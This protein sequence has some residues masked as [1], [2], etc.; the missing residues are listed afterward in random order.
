MD[1]DQRRAA[2]WARIAAIRDELDELL[3]EL[4]AEPQRRRPHLTVLRGGLGAVAI[5][6]LWLARQRPRPGSV[7]ATTVGL[8]VTAA[9]VTAIA[10]PAPLSRQG[11]APPPVFTML[12]TALVTTVAATGTIGASPSQSG[13]SSI[14]AL[15]GYTTAATAVGSS[16]AAP[17]PSASSTAA[18]SPNRSPTGSGSAAPT[19]TATGT[20][21]GTPTPPASCLVTL[22]VNGIINICLL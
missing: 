14:P 2:I 22:G 5:P 18:A 10:V 7:V 19:G 1:D 15:T 4:G 3:A 9:A 13:P 11:V 20:A 21:T 16:P 6:V 12:D 17:T 8:G